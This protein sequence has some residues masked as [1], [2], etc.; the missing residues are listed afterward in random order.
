MSLPSRL[1]VL[2]RRVLPLGLAVGIAVPAAAFAA[3]DSTGGDFTV[4]NVRELAHHTGANAAVW[5]PDG[6]QIAA[7]G[8]FMR[9]VTL[10]DSENSA[11]LREFEIAKGPGA[12]WSIAFTPDGK[13]VV[14]TAGGNPDNDPGAGIALWNASTG[15]LIRYL[16]GPAPDKPSAANA[17]YVFSMAQ[18]GERLAMGPVSAVSDE[19]AVYA[20]DEWSSP[21]ILALRRDHAEALAFS[22]DGQRLAVGT[23]GRQLLL[24]DVAQRKS[25]WSTLAYENEGL[26][27]S[28]VAYSPD[29]RFIATASGGPMGRR[30]WPGG[31]FEPDLSDHPLAIW[32]AATGSFV[33]GLPGLAQEIRSLSWSDDG[34]FLA[35]TQDDETV[36]FWA[37]DTPEKSPVE[38]KLP[39]PVTSVAFAP[40]SLKFVVAANGSA[41][42]GEIAPR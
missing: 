29:G 26:G 22:P 27:V 12:C 10:W 15:E 2:F 19:I 14:T 41:F 31:H 4:G 17:A 8:W 18:T 21:A 23:I 25:L 35:A 3:S 24:F 9:R 7:L 5:S 36:R 40:D 1:R 6:K 11:K 38:L 42:V 37:M 30:V 33:R 13:S 34:R 32:D 39:K 20:G 28:A 16:P